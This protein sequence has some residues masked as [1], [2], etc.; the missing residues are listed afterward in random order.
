MSTPINSSRAHIRS[1]HKPLVEL[2]QRA[3]RS[4]HIAA[5][6]ESAESGAARVAYA[7]LGKLVGR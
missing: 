3:R 5:G 2:L 1:T 4:K 7:R 6:N